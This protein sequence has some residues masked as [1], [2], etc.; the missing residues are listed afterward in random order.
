MTFAPRGRSMPRDRLRQP[1]RTRRGSAR[2]PRSS[3]ASNPQRARRMGCEGSSPRLRVCAASWRVRF[4]AD[5][6]RTRTRISGETCESARR[7]IP[8]PRAAAHKRAARSGLPLRDQRERRAQGDSPSKSPSQRRCTPSARRFFSPVVLAAED[9]H[10]GRVL[11]FQGPRSWRAG[12]QGGS[13]RARLSQDYILPL[14]AAWPIQDTPNEFRADSS[15]CLPFAFLTAPEKIHGNAGKENPETDRRIS[16]VSEYRIEDNEPGC[17]NKQNRR[18]RMAGDAD[19]ISYISSRCSFTLAAP[20]DEQANC[21]QPEEEKVH[22]HHIA[23]NL[24]VPP[25]KGD[26][27]RRQAL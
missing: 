12:S 1:K 14:S 8:L 18:H 25:R 20:E 11:R 24:V 22:G 16:R 27:Y 3:A 4:R 23:Q 6:A 7:G 2:S 15:H 17:R 10:S 9:I 5:P 13:R 19:V 21:G 26:D